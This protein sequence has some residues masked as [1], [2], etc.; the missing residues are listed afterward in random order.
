MNN[1]YY[2]NIDAPL[3]VRGFTIEDAD[4]DYNVYINSLLSDEAAQKTREHELRH[5]KNGDF[6]K[7]IS[8]HEIESQYK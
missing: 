7:D 1:I 8:A 2:R 3:T 5:I 6:Q 4:G